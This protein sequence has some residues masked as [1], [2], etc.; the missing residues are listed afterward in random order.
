MSKLASISADKT[1]VEYSQGAAQSAASAVAD[2]LAPTVPVGASV[3][4]FK[5]YSQKNRF[6]IPDTRRAL[7]GDATV[8]GFS[9][10]DSTFNCEPH[11]LD[12]P[13]DNLEMIETD[14]LIDLMKEGADMIADV[15]SLSH[16]KAV[17]DLALSTVGA[18][19]AL[20]IG[21][22]DDVV[23]QLDANILAV[24]KAAK[25]GGL[26]DI[27][28][29]IGAGA[30]GVVKNHASV[31]SRFLAG[32]KDRF[33]VPDL[34]DFGQMLIARPEARVSLMCYDTAPEGKAESI[35]F[36]LD[37]DILVFARKANPNRFD[38]SFMKTF[39]LRNKWMVP[40]TYVRPDGRG[41]VAKFDWSEDI[42][43]TNSAAAVRRTVALS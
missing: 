35:S 27:G 7:N 34:N 5:V 40:G 23:A 6:R 30:W 41:E 31:K 43:V 18:G 11:A 1:L 33:A 26:M 22:S 12:F 32:S 25:M 14:G 15:A 13:I 2:F 16:E 21:G 38:P 29:L 8:I 42:Q 39:R 36:V 20:S 4:K 24:I 10:S 28:V 37:G 17:I 3:G 19:T 9:A